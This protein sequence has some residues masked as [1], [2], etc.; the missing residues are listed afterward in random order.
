MGWRI[1]E[2]AAKNGFGIFATTLTV[3]PHKDYKLITEIGKKFAA[4][5]DIQF[6]DKNFKKKAGFQR[7]VELSKEY[8]LYRQDYCGCGF[9]A[10]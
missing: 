8:G 6:L 1:A 3:S 4:E 10:R 2:Y 9:S 7:S 5:Y